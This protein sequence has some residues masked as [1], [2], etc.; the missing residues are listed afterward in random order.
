[1]S[2]ER[3]HG[4]SKS[5]ARRVGVRGPLRA[6]DLFCGAGGL[7]QGFRDAG[8]DVTFA[9]DKDATAMATYRANHPDTTTYLGSITELTPAQILD[10][11]GGHVD[12]VIGGPSCQ[13]FS[14]AGRKNGW[15]RE[16]DER[17]HLWTHMLDVVEHLQPKAFLMENVPGLVYWREG[18]FGERIIRRFERLNYHVSHKILLAAD[19]GVPQRRRRLFM[20]GLRGQGLFDFPEPTHHGGWRRDRLAEADAERRRLGLMRHISCWEAI[21]DLPSIGSGP[22]APEM[23]RTASRATPFVRAI[24]NGTE[25]V[26][27]HEVAPLSEDQQAL[28]RHV[29]PGGTWRDVPPHLLP[30]RFRGMRRTDSTNL[31][32]RL[33]P[34]LPSY[35]MTTQFTNVTV[36]CNTHPFEPRSLSVREGARLQTF[37]DTYR[38]RGSVASRARQIGNAV[39]PV[40]AHA[41]AFAIARQM[42]PYKARKYHVAWVPIRPA[43]V[44]PGP[45]TDPTTKLRMKRQK[46][47]DTRPELLIRKGLFARGLR[48]RVNYRPIPDLRRTAD[49]VFPRQTLAVFIDGCFWHGCPKHSRDTKSN[50]VWWRDKIQANRNRDAETTLKLQGKGWR[51]IRIWEHT[52]PEEAVTIITAAL[53]EAE[54][55]SEGKTQVTGIR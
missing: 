32:G 30:D 1:V 15:V 28:V 51:V 31:L 2:G 34:S 50:T 48:Y 12:V 16:D 43:A 54:P 44:Q 55:R 18:E 53:A 47:V 38:F 22:G 11:A 14:T 42:N 26:R 9:V 39:P 36:G 37:P 27:D 17:V 4:S 13:G 23:P 45:P 41:L 5:Q 19:F 7:T 6:I 21:G 3:Q 46:R 20:V 10:L 49:L 52:P 40:L 24:R 8:F 33:D 25:T 35:T 29:P